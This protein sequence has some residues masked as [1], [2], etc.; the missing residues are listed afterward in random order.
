M[1]DTTAAPYSIPYLKPTEAADIPYAG[2]IMAERLVVL[3]SEMPY[4]KMWKASGD[5]AYVADAAATI[6]MSAS[7]VVGGMTFTDA[8]DTLTVPMAGLYRIECGAYMAGTASAS[9]TALGLLKN[10]VWLDYYQ[11]PTNTADLTI[12]G[13]IEI[14]L[15][16]NDAL[17][18]A[19]IAGQNTIL[20]GSG[21]AK[22]CWLSAR[23]LRDTL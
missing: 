1:P 20:R 12:R 19:F 21:E 3:M 16:A 13:G 17:S 4:G 5:Q 7:R 2:Q 9:Y 11:Q 22:S 15:A 10:G 14:N 23:W 8:S 18:L 6:T